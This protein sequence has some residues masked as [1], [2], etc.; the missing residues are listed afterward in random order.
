MPRQP[1]P[2][3]FHDP[4]S[5]SMKLGSISER[6]ELASIV[7]RCLGIWTNAE[8]QMA[9]LLSILLKADSEAA[10]AVYLV[11]RR[12]TPRYEALTAAANVT[13]NERDRRLFG[14]VMLVYQAAEAERNALAHGIF[15]T[16]SKMPNSLLWLDASDATQSIIE[17]LRAH[18]AT[19]VLPPN[20]DRALAEKLFYYSDNALNSV[21]HQIETVLRILFD[22]NIYLR[23][24]P[25]A[26]RDQQYDQL[27][28]QAPIREALR[29][30][31]QREQKNKTPAHR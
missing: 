1:L 12:S 16:H 27:C 5:W 22:L 10:V 23:E 11:L 17:A 4:K 2:K 18:T 9:I 15:G 21:S 8:L 19:G 6:P 20:T 26:K 14:A 30:Q 3:K 28:S 25:G 7:G 31:Q 24:P 29:V 13:L